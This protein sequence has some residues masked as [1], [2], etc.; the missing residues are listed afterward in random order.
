MNRTIES[1]YDAASTVEVP[2]VPL[3][4]AV[5]ALN[6]ILES[7]ENSI[8]SGKGDN[9]GLFAEMFI[10]QIPAYLGALCLIMENV[11][12]SVSDLESGVARIYEASKEQNGRGEKPH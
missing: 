4:R 2:L 7:M 5:A 9:K 1:L 12:T 8:P 10:E 3:Q 11:T 6:I